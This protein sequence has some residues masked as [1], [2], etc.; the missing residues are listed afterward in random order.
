MARSLTAQI[1]DALELLLYAERYRDSLLML[2]LEPG[3]RLREVVDALRVFELAHIRCIV[4]SEAYEGLAEELATLSRR[5]ITLRYVPV[6]ADIKDFEISIVEDTIPVLGVESGSSLLT[7]CQTAIPL[8]PIL[9]VRKLFICLTDQSTLLEKARKPLLNPAE[10][11]QLFRGENLSAAE[12]ELL[13]LIRAEVCSKKREIVLL[14]GDS[15][16]LFQEVFTHLGCGTMLTATPPNRA[17]VAELSDVLAISNLMRPYVQEGVLLP[18]N[19]DTVARRVGEF[20]VY[21]ANDAVIG[22]ARLTPYGT[23]GELGSI[24]T[25]PRYRG[26]GLAREIAAAIFGVAESRGYDMVFSLSTSPTMWEFFLSLGMEI[27][28]REQ[29]PE[30]WQALYDFA[31]PSKAFIKRLGSV[32]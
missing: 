24:C 18:M 7:L 15:S 2:A 1:E 13:R 3:V 17:R 19:E 21:T 32:V 16:S 20:L 14:D 29:L 6:A 31:R 8:L 12:G 23:G 26:Q 11:E 10:I 22:A 5:G 28:E 9:N 30:S 4:V 25:L 27:I